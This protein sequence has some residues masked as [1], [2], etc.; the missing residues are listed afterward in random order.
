MEL[1]G[2]LEEAEELLS[3][4]MLGQ[5]VMLLMAHGEGLNPANARLQRWGGLLYDLMD[6]IEMPTSELEPLAETLR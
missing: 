2:V 5:E 6:L 1:L 4:G 3:S